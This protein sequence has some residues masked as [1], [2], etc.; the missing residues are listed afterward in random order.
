V[1]FDRILFTLGTERYS[2]AHDVIDRQ[3]VF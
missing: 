2:R 1:A 3:G